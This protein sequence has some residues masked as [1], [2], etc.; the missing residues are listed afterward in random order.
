MAS[1]FALDVVDKSYSCLIPT[2]LGFRTNSETSLEHWEKSQ[3]V[4]VP[5]R[6]L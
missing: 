1:H 5:K 2:R 4:R 3:F 6:R